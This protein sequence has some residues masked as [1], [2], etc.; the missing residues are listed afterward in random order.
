MEVCGER[1]EAMRTPLLIA[2]GRRIKILRAVKGISQK[3]LAAA[4]CMDDA[5]IC[6]YES[7]SRGMQ[8]QTIVKICEALDTTPNYLFGFEK[9]TI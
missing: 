2:I 9:T 3:E 1:E 8:P 4:I 7:G 5:T 6:L